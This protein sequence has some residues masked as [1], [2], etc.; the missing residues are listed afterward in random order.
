MRSKLIT[1]RD[2]IS[3]PTTLGDTSE[4]NWI[5]MFQNYIPTRYTVDKGHVL[6]SQGN[7]SDQIDVVI[8][9]RHYSPF[10]FNEGGAKYFPAESVYA[11]LEVK[12]ELD[13]E[14]INYAGKKAASVRQLHRTSANIIHLGDTQRPRELF[15]ILAGV[16][17]LKS[18]WTPSFGTPFET[19]IMELSSEQRLNFGCALESGSFRIDYNAASP[20]TFEV[21]TPENSLIF[22]FL[23]LLSRLQELGTVS[24]MDISAYGQVL[25]R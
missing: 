16:L 8:Y 13:K 5:E 7:I 10:F 25:R 23:N 24:A 1:A 21:S 2:G 11:V 3:H 9:D 18:S 14:N 17:T 12:Q 4:V 15:E 19:S 6:D 22:F 20:H